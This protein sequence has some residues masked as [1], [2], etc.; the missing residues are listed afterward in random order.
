MVGG[1]LIKHWSSTQKTI[2]LSSGEA[3]LSGILKGASEGLGAQS[4]AKDLG[5]ELDLIIR[6]DS[7]AAIG[8]FQRHG[9][10]KVRHLAMGSLWAQQRIREGDFRLFKC[11][12]DHNIGD[13]LTKHVP[14]DLLVR[15]TLAAGMQFVDGRPESAPSAPQ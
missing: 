10:G 1:H 9:L 7:S 15:H 5:L 2:A 6:A 13:L 12:G 3:E 4:L 11:S 8:I 14:N